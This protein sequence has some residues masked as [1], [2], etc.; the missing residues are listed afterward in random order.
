MADPA[1]M[2]AR[3]RQALGRTNPLDQP[4][5]PPAIDEPVVRLVHTDLGLGELFAHRAA[6]NKMQVQ[7]VHIEE[8]LPALA[9]FLRARD[10]HKVVMPVSP[11][12]Q[13]L[14]LPA[15]LPLEGVELRT[16]DEVSLDETYE[17]DCGITDVYAA[18][19]ETGSLVIRPSP[20]HGR[21]ISLMPPIHVAIVEPKN[22]VPDLVDLCELLTRESSASGTV[23]ITGP[24][25]TA[26]IEMNLVIG[27][28][29][30]RMVQ[31]F[32]LQ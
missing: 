32:L 28:H 30:P 27:V 12:L 15:A 21:A 18:V 25:K 22:L 29:G 10:C 11:F 26:D 4:P 14:G 2:L 9:A 6:D 8:L 3:I 7:A 31:V 19:A 23:I 24:S 20:E 13:K 16:W 17:Y 1:D 5:V